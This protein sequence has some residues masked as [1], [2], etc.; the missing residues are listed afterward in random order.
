MR[1]GTTLVL[2]ASIVAV[3]ADASRAQC[4]RG[5]PGG[6]RSQSSS[7]SQSADFAQSGFNPALA[8]QQRQIQLAMLQQQVARQNY[9]RQQLLARAQVDQEKLDRKRASAASRRAVVIAK[10][11]KVRRENL[12]RLEAKRSR[13]SQQLEATAF[14]AVVEP[15][16]H[17]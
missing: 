14:V 16:A 13:Q 5:G 8:A 9:Q 2:A 4:Q 7:F 10:R 15:T 3:A 1:F 11:E 12:A 17:E 6:M